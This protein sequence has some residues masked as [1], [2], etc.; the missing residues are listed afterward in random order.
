M[1]VAKKL[2]TA[3]EFWEL[4]GHEHAELVR[5][6]VVE[7]MPPGGI[8]G[9]VAAEITYILKAWVK[10]EG[11]GRVGQEAGFVVG[12]NPDKVRVPDV[13]FIR[14]ERIPAEGVP[15]GFWPIAP[16]LVVEVISPSDTVE[17]VREKLEDYFAAG[18]SEIWL[19]YPR[20]KLIEVCSPSGVTRVFRQEDTLESPH[21]LPGFSCKVG[22]VVSL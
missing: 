22:E 17:V 8:H 21:L 9:E 16:D 14:R 11:L 13:Y 19:V 20:A 6:E 3:E 18:S 5:G 4:P 12:R 1:A 2:L 15:E 10:R 7:R